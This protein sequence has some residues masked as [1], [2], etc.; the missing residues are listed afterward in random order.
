MEKIA[1]VLAGGLGKRM[2][3]HLPK[4]AIRIGEKSM[5]QI[6]LNKLYKLGLTKIYVVYGQKGDLLKGS[7]ELD[8]R[9][10]WVHQDPQFGT[11]HALQVA[12]GEVEERFGDV[13]VCNGD[14]PFVREGTMERLVGGNRL[15]VCRVKNP[16]G[17]GRIIIREGGFEGI[18]EDK[19]CNE[20]ERLIERIN[21]G[22]YGFDLDW[23][24]ENVGKLDNNN[25]QGEY[26]LTDLMG[27]MVRQG[28][29]VRLEE[30]EDEDEI[31]NV[32]NPEQLAY[33]QTIV[34]KYV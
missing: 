5:L 15:L 2:N 12:I 14:A 30:I 8:D 13:L 24:R 28:V 34:G 22:V 1:I 3:S 6:V 4:P 18:V 31:Y 19:D 29:K 20:N 26:Y 27:M 11:G 10:V 33:A 7:V 21:A 16:A 9:I 17:Y 23:L 32:N 25:A